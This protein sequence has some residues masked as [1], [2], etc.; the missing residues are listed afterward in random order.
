MVGCGGLKVQGTGAEEA[1][2]GTWKMIPWQWRR[3]QVACGEEA[4]WILV[5]IVEI[6]GLNRRDATFSLRLLFWLLS[7]YNYEVRSTLQEIYLPLH[8]T[9]YYTY[10]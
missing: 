7:L 6:V 5:T 2:T 8:H 10:T 3:Y 9:K 1:G 4:R